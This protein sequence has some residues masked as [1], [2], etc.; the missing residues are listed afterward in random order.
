MVRRLKKDVLTQLPPKRRNRIA[1][2]PDK[3][4]AKKLKEVQERLQI[5]KAFSEETAGSGGVPPAVV[6]TF[7]L[8][9]EAKVVAVA[10]YME[11]LVSNEIKF[12]IFA[13]HHVMLDYL[14]QKLKDLGTQHI[15]IDGKTPQKDR[16]ELVAK[17]QDNESVRVAVLSITACGAGLTLTAAHTVVFAELYWVPGQMMQ[18]EDRA[19]RIGQ[20]H[21][22][23]VHY[24]IAENTLD[25]VMFKSLNKKQRDTTKILNGAEVCL[26]ARNHT[27]AM[28]GWRSSRPSV[29]SAGKRPAVEEVPNTGLAKYFK[30]SPS[31]E[32]AAEAC[33]FTVEAQSGA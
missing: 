15:R 33:P 7:T 27:P 4:D 28:E 24:C 12:L 29:G 25:D 21:S 20:H 6:E 32:A 1:M 31:K 2:P 5:E 14:E 9:A 16:Q 18:A 23:D 8:T 26:E 3:M 30:S 22:V 19:H 17:F 11:Y 13:H 10:E